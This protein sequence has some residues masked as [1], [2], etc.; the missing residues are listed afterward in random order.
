MNAPFIT[1]A[2]DGFGR[3]G[4]TN[5]DI[6]RLIEAGVIDPDEQFELIKGEIVPMS[7]EYNRHLKARAKLLRI[8][9]PALSDEWCVVTEGSLFLADNVEFKP[10]LHIFPMAMNS[11]DVRGPDV[12]LAIELASTTQRRDFELKVPI[13]AECGVPE[14]W[15]I[16]LDARIGSVFD[17]I[18]G[19][20]YAASRRVGSEDLLS[21][22]AFPSVSL[23]VRDLY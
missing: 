18:E 23:R 22:R 12:R 7:P 16:D 10:D 15:V 17:R 11:E 21:P 13:Y 19:K 8:F 4:F 20:V 14:L 6:A 5:S 2:A 9:V 1:R 3:R